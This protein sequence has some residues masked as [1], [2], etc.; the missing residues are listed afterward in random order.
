MTKQTIDLEYYGSIWQPGLTC[1]NFQTI[2]VGKGPFE[3]D[4]ELTSDAIE[5]WLLSHTGDYDQITDWSAHLVT[6]SYVDGKTVTTETQIKDWVSED[7]E[8]VFLS[9]FQHTYEN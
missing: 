6:T 9:C 5:D 3:V 8:L 7:S 4:I 1:A 2:E